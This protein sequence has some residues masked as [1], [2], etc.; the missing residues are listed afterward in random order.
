MIPIGRR[1]KRGKKEEPVKRDHV[2]TDSCC[3][4]LDDDKTMKKSPVGNEYMARCMN[5]GMP[6]TT[7]H[8]LLHNLANAS[9]HKKIE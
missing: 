3:C 4:V 5:D 8:S 7:A 9:T 2:K 1:K 6:H